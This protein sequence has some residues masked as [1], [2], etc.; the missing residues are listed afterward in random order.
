MYS[1]CEDCE[2]TVPADQRS[3]GLG[4][5]ATGR[6]Y[7]TVT[8][9]GRPGTAQG[10]YTANALPLNAWSH[11]AATYDGKTLKIYLNGVPQSSAAYSSDGDIFAGT[12]DLGIGASV[13]GST[14]YFFAGKLDEPAHSRQSSAGTG[15]VCR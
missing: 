12:G 11:V 2:A 9:D 8:R 15:K 3:Y 10:V 1:P 6:G 13:V 7:F 4:I 14:G 5:D